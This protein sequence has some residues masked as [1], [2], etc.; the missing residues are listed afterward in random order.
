MNSNPKK[1]QI[2]EN[3]LVLLQDQ[4]DNAMICPWIPP[5]YQVN[6]SKLASKTPQ[7]VQ[8]YCCSE[9]QHFHHKIEDTDVDKTVSTTCGC[10]VVTHPITEV[11]KPKSILN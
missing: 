10:T 2:D 6:E 8:P 5:Y 3:G 9:C 4:N 7:I 1:V 11:I